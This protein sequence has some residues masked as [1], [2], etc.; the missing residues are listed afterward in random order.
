MSNGIL[1]PITS[2]P[3]EGNATIAWRD[4]DSAPVFDLFESAFEYAAI[5]MA[6]VGTDNR[7]LRVNRALCEMLGYSNTD[8]T[9]LTFT[10]ITHP[11][12]LEQD[13]SRTRQLLN[14]EI[15]T[16]QSEKRYIHNEGRV[17]WVNL[18]VSLVRNVEGEPLFF[19]SQY[20]DIS[21]RKRT[22]QEL[23]L[24]NVR[25]AKLIENFQGGL[26]IEDEAGT[27][28]MLNQVF[29]DMFG[30]LLSPN[31]MIGQA[32]TDIPLTKLANPG[33][34]VGRLHHIAEKR[35]PVSAERIMMR[36]GRVLERDYTPITDNGVALGN[37]WLYRDITA[38]VR[39][40][41]RM[42]Q[43][44]QNLQVANTALERMALTD[45]LT[46]MNNRRAF[47]QR[48]EEE[49]ARAVAKASVISLLITDID[50]FKL[51]NDDFGHPA[52]DLILREVAWILHQYT[53]GSD[54]VARYGGEE[55]AILLPH[56][57]Y[58]TSLEIGERL[59]RAVA[60]HTWLERPLTASF[61]IATVSN[62][63]ANASVEAMAQALIAVADD[64]LYRAKRVGR[65]C[66]VHANDF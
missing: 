49:I 26:L 47:M 30:I 44:A 52:G 33:Q 50:H 2:H 57:D 55:F 12:D 37:L 40:Y 41:T 51:Y 61:G 59:R 34:F 10:A 13:L 1:V 53:R 8:L 66:V 43:H 5:G 65:N 28:F 38:R 31:S 32:V 18:S 62:F 35:L 63:E 56:A 15:S 23:R 24:T 3:P 16:F 19:I 7:F 48:L 21:E 25:F 60:T 6:I 17:V 14:G 64:A 20:Q 29:C 9:S 54:Y 46:G 58:R 36:D 22:E 4:S 45:E 27:I 39:A 42:E 11:Q